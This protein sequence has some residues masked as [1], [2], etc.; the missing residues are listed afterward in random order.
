MSLVFF[1]LKIYPFFGIGLTVLCWDLSRSLRR[2]ANRSWIGMALF[3]LLF[4]STTALWIGFR[5]DRNADL[6]FAR[7]DSWLRVGSFR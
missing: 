1:F 6:W 3:G 4:F 7:L 2:R 5:G